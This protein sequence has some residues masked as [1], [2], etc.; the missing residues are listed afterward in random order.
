MP[1]NGGD[2][3]EKLQREGFIGEDPLPTEYLRVVEGLTPHE[4]DVLIA[5]RRRLLAADEFA[6]AS[7][8]APGE[9]EMFYSKVKF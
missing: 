7:P 4:V 9:T 5:V 1:S 8:A 3:L 2:N 6:D